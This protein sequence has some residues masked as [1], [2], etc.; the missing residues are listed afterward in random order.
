MWHMFK[1]VLHKVTQTSRPV[2]DPVC[3]SQ[4]VHSV[5]IV[6]CKRFQ[7]CYSTVFRWYSENEA[8][9]AKTT[10]RLDLEECALQ[11]KT[12][13]K[14]P[15][16]IALSTWGI[17]PNL[18]CKKQDRSVDCMNSREK[19]R[20]K[21]AATLLTFSQS[22]EESS[23][24]VIRKKNISGKCKNF[25]V[26]FS[27]SRDK[28]EKV[29]AERMENKLCCLRLVT[30]KIEKHCTF[31]RNDWPPAVSRKQPLVKTAPL[32]LR[33]QLDSLTQSAIL[34]EILLSE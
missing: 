17:Q 22:R 9:V 19:R 11:P 24:K 32:V 18:V 7:V 31:G 1:I 20:T 29:E 23:E 6:F 10:K 13:Q 4:F 33:L 14:S 28:S 8:T 30:N 12:Q 3:L 26:L 16:G 34:A 25:H 2:H 15:A 5:V 27:F 21:G